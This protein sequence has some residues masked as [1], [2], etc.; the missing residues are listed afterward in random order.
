MRG[1][2]QPDFSCK[3]K[4]VDAEIY[5]YM[6]CAGQNII[7]RV[8]PKSTARPQDEIKVTFDTSRIHIFDKE[9]ELT[10]SN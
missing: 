10:I 8:D 4:P 2:E 3:D 5:L 9:T 6:D 7:A 1:F